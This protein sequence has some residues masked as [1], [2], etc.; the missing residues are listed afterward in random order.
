MRYRVRDLLFTLVMITFLVPVFAVIS[1]LILLLHGRPVFFVE[2]RIGLY[3]KLF[4]IYKFRTLAVNRGQAMAATDLENRIVKNGTPESCPGGFLKFLRRYSLDE[5]P[6]IWNVLKGDM[7]LVGP[8]PMPLSEL[9]YRFGPDAS[10]VTAVPP[11]L[12]GLW[13][14]SGRNDLPLEERHRLDLVYAETKSL[15]LDFKIMF[16]TVYTVVSGKGAY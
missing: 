1:M 15:L 7:S 16:K 5:L 4:I 13:Q 3:G 9:E 12:T 8:R 2:K 10:K 14:V 6:Q 11:G